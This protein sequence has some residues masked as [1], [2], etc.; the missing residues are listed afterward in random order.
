MKI[1]KIL[2]IILGITQIPYIFEEYFKSFQLKYYGNNKSRMFHVLYQFISKYGIIETEIMYI[3]LNIIYCNNNLSNDNNN[4]ENK[5]NFIV[6]FLIP[7]KLVL[8]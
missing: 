4:D 8:I 6:I 5:S 1:L 7:V 3:C 2:N